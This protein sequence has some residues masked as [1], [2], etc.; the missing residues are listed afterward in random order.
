MS[1]PRTKLNK[2]KGKEMLFLKMIFANLKFVVGVFYPYLF[3]GFTL[4]LKYYMLKL[5]S[6]RVFGNNSVQI[7]LNHRYSIVYRVYVNNK[8]QLGKSVNCILCRII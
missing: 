6:L 1:K 5:D 3:Y 4:I 8:C 7:N 2:R